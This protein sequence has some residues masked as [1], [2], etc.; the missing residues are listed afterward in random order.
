MAVAGG[1][2]DGDKVGSLTDFTSSSCLDFGP[3]ENLAIAKLSACMPWYVNAELRDEQGQPT[4]AARRYAPLVAKL[5][6]L[7]DA[8]WEEFQP[9]L[10]EVDAEHS[11]A[12]AEAGELHY[13]IRYNAFMGV[14]SDFFLA[15]DAGIEWATA[16]AKPVPDRLADLA[17][18]AAADEVC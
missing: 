9:R 11:A 16:A 17:L 12:A 10:R 2:V 5:D 3:E 15:E 4:P 1:Y 6:A 18:L 13:A 7:D 14:R 8:A